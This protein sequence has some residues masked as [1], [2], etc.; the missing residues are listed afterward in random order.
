MIP[1]RNSVPVRYPATATYGLIGT[2][3]L[4]FLFQISLP[5]D[6]EEAFLYL[7]GLVPA[8][9]TDPVWARQVGLP[10]DWGLPFVSNMFLHGGWLH[11]I[12]NMWTLWLFGGAVEDRLGHGRY[13]VFYL[14]CGVAAG[15]AHAW[16][17]ANSTVP[18][19]GASGAIAGVLGADGRFF[20]RA[21]LVLLVPVL[22]IPLFFE[23]PALLYVALWFALQVFQGLLDTIAP[24]V[25]GVAWWAH[26][27]GFLAGV[28]L[29][30]AVHRPRRTYRPYYADEG[31]LGFGPRG[32][33]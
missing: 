20:P 21:W 17:N 8:R 5:P 23:V 28:L 32:Q 25:G 10:P 16:V 15:G 29:A 14:A 31:V 18:A 22:F 13:L 6:A 24:E 33:R 4:V 9:Y 12:L 27:G 30:P 3:V 7:Y 19:V 1:I 11:L 2:N 26:I